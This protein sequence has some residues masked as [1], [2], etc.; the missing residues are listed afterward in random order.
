MTT[1][2]QISDEARRIIDRAI[3][4]L[5]DYDGKP[6]TNARALDW[7]LQDILE[8]GSPIAKSLVRDEWP[9]PDNIEFWLETPHEHLPSTVDGKWDPHCRKCGLELD[10]GTLEPIKPVGEPATS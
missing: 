10:Q 4:H 1:R 8:F 9:S 7:L 5:R 3:E 2:V 6:C